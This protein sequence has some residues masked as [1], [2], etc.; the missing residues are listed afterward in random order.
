[1]A[2]LPRLSLAGFPHLIMQRGNNGQPIFSSATDYETMLGLLADSSQKF[3]VDI[4]AYVLLPDHFYILATPQTADGLPLMMQ[5]IGRAYVRWFNNHYGRT[6]TLWDGRYKSTVIDAD[7]DLLDTM[8][9]MDSSPVQAG[10]VAQVADYV[11]SSHTNFIG[12]GVKHELDKRLEP[13]F[14]YWNIGNTPFAREMKYAELVKIGMSTA[15]RLQISDAIRKGWVQG[16]PSFV[17][18]VQA[19]TTRRVMKKSAGRPFA[20]KAGKDMVIGV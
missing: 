15:R 20:N 4:N 3:N 16:T 7:N 5:A 9:Y 13:H 14:A 12:H 18:K 17:T 10:L 8:V 2:R 6:G 19:L 1:M 11:W